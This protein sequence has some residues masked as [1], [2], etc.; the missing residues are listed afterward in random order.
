MLR[1]QTPEYLPMYR[2]EEYAK[3]DLPIISE[4]GNSSL[5]KNPLVEGL[6]G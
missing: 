2:A 1:V 4:R 6:A 3:D 5:Y